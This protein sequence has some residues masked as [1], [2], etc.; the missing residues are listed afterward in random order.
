MKLIL[1]FHLYRVV[2]YIPLSAVPSLPPQDFINSDTANLQIHTINGRVQ[3]L[4]QLIWDQVQE[5][6]HAYHVV[7]LLAPAKN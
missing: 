3:Y 6:L 7:P 1:S 5:M 4:S 2:Q